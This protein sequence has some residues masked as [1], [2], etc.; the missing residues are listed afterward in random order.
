L[1][2]LREARTCGPRKCYATA[3]NARAGWARAIAER[4]SPDEQRVLSRA[5]EILRRLVED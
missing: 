5:V 1:C 3:T 2:A 4:L